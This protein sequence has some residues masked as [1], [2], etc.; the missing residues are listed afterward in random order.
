MISDELDSGVLYA[1]FQFRQMRN[2][3]YLKDNYQHIPASTHLGV[4]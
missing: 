1:K 4:K 3:E 2:E